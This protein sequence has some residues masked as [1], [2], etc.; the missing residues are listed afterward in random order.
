M[1]E[2]YAEVAIA[3]RIQTVAGDGVESELARNCFAAIIRMRKPT[4]LM[5]SMPAKSSTSTPLLPLASKTTASAD[6]A[7]STISDEN[8]LHRVSPK[9]P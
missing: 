3:N 1:E 5:Y 7:C 8:A 6:S 2:I 9:K 4:L